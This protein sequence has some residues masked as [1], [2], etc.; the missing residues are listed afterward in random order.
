MYKV[1]CTSYAHK[2]Y[3]YSRDIEIIFADLCEVF[4]HKSA[5]II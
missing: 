4:S 5:K 2:K 1:A 3:V